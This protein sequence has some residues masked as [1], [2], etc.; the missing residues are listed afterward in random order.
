M[1]SYCGRGKQYQAQIADFQ[2]D[3]VLCTLGEATAGRE[4]LPGAILLQ[5]LPKGRE[6]GSDHSKGSGNRRHKDS[7]AQT[8]RSVVK[9]EGRRA[10]KRLQR[11]RRI[12]LK[13]QSKRG[14]SMCAASGG[15]HKLSQWL[16]GQE[17]DPQTLFLVPGRKKTKWGLVRC[18][19]HR[20]ALR[21]RF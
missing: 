18:T 14:R 19:E 2:N 5:G 4:N 8:R 11:W 7:G 10:E 13:L 15:Y 17:P 12:A 20:G 9:L 6:A 3:Q 21:Y 1:N 16:K